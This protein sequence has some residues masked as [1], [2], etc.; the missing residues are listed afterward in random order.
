MTRTTM[1]PTENWG[2]SRLPL[3]GKSMSITPFRS[4]SS[5]TASSTGSFSASGL[6][7]LSPKVS[8]SR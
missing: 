7:I 5:E 4:F 6:S 3:I 1:R 2:S 8:W